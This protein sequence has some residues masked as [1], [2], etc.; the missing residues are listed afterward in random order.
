MKQYIYRDSSIQPGESALL[1]FPPSHPTV[2]LQQN[3]SL[4]PRNTV[5]LWTPSTAHVVNYHR[6]HQD[7][8]KGFNTDQSCFKS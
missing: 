4:G 3:N 8:L 6:L 7:G 1:T 5:K 2:L